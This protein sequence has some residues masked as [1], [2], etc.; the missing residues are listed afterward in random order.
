MAD[1][2]DEALCKYNCKELRNLIKDTLTTKIKGLD[3]IKK[4][5]LIELIM[6]HE[7]EFL[8]KLGI[9]IKKEIKENTENKE[10]KKV[11]IIK[12][13]EPKFEA[14]SMKFIIG[15]KRK[16]EYI[17]LLPKSMHNMKLKN[18]NPLVNYFYTRYK[19][20]LEE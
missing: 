20:G 17:Y 9:P 15:C 16:A 7:E 3:K 8:E 1:Y 13:K 4:I 19:E 2:L 5:D 11:E 10:N 12:N 14:H 18:S 6:E